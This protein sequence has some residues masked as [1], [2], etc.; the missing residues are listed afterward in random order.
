M[1]GEL[2]CLTA[3]ALGKESLVHNG[4]WRL[5]GPRV[6]LGTEAGWE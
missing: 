6:G 4:D 2:H 3:V 5:G 1:S